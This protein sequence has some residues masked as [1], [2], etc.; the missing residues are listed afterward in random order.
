MNPIDT[1]IATGNGLAILALADP[2]AT[3]RELASKWQKAREAANAELAARDA[4]AVRLYEAF[5]AA[6][7]GHR[8]PAQRAAMLAFRAKFRRDDGENWTRREEG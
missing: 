7:I 2:T 8:T 5:D 1:L 6:D 3:A 4:I